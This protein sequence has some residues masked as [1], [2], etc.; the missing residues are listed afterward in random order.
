[1]IEGAI[2]YRLKKDG[3]VYECHP[4]DFHYKD[5]TISHEKKVL[6]G[7]HIVTDTVILRPGDYEIIPQEDYNEFKRQTARQ[8]LCTLINKNEQDNDDVLIP[9]A[10]ELTNKLIK[11]L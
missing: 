3:K 11:K 10:I 2:R 5:V 6:W 7:D 9:R 1:M 4:L 8:I